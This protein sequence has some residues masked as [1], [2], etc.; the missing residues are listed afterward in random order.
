M[1]MK[2]E[3]DEF[4][5]YLKEVKKTSDNTRVSYVRDLNQFERFL[6]QLGKEEPQTVTAADF[7]AYIDD[8]KRQNKKTA[9]VSR[10]IASVRAF[11]AYLMKKGKATKNITEDVVA[12]KVEKKTPDILSQA[13]VMKLLNQPS[14]D[15]PKEIR[16]R[17]MLE[18]LYGTGIRVSELITLKVQDIDFR[19]GALTC[20]DGI[21]KRVIPFGRV[22]KKALTRYLT[23][24]REVLL[25][26]DS[27]LLFVNCSGKSMSR[28]GFWKLI[29]AYATKAG[30]QSEI[31]PH[32]LRHSFAAHLLENGADLKSV[33][34]MMGHSD[35]SSTLIYANIKPNRLRTVYATAHP[36]G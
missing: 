13:E 28:Q 6:V 26:E 4:D 5:V 12:P 20:T 31:T 27:E 8:L 34:E 1:G 16:D 22:A 9:T 30:I 21:H 19:L 35:I 3:I 14:G 17:A 7:N 11:Y 33:K 18:L 2:K 24:S 15:T 29:K 25:Q 32:T 23:E 10:N 36:R